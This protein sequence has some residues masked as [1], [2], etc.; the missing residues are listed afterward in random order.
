[1][2]IGVATSDFAIEMEDWTDA[3]VIDAAMATLTKACEL[4]S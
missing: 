4:A 1:M 3:R 2:L